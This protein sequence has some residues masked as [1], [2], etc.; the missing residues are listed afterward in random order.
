M[1]GP[2]L[3]PVNFILFGT[4]IFAV[5]I[6]LKISRGDYPGLFESAIGAINVLVGEA[7]GTGHTQR[8]GPYED[9]A[10]V[11]ED[12][13]REDWSDTA[14]SN[15]RGHGSCHTLEGVRRVFPQ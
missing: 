9:R 11:F 7:E 6:K 2:N 13:S 10:E 12:A 8:E 3:E 14:A 5:M 4:R 15:T 1:S